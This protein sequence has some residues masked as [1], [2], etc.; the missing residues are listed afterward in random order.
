MY[1]G[2]QVKS[3]VDVGTYTVELSPSETWLYADGYW[4]DGTNDPREY[5]FDITPATLTASVKDVYIHEGEE[6]SFNVEVS[7]FVAKENAGTAAGYEAPV[8]SLANGV[9]ASSLKAGETCEIVVSGGSAKN[10][11]FEYEN[12]TLHVL[13]AD[14]ACLPQAMK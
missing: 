6:P 13:A 11:K 12:A 3:F 14:T 8:A 7:G 1:N 10:Y 5:S 9:D 4:P 2:L